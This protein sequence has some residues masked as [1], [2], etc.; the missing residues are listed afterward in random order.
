MATRFL[1][2]ISNT[3]S[4]ST[5]ADVGSLDPTKY[6]VYFNDFDTYVLG[7][8]TITTKEDGAGSATEALDDA[9]GGVL[10]VTNAGGDD[11]NDFFNKKGE[12]FTLESGKKA[13]F[14]SRFKVSNATGSDFVIGLQQ[15]DTSPLSVNNGVYFQKDDGDTNLDFKSSNGGAT[16]AASALAT[17]ADDTYVTVGFY[18]AGGTEIQYFSDNVKR[19]SLEVETTYLPTTELTVSFGLQNGTTSARTMSVDYIFAAKER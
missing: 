12:S 15:T 6:H 14:R 5:L 10:L 19:G 1:D 16:L 4:T 8:W 3:S 13:W 2:G 7:D 9:D 11:D 18:H 17:V